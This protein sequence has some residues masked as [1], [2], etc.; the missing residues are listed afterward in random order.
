MTPSLSCCMHVRLTIF[1]FQARERFQQ[2]FNLIQ[3]LIRV[4]RCIIHLSDEQ[5]M[6]TAVEMQWYAL[7]QSKEARKLA[8]N[9]AYYSKSKVTSHILLFQLL[10][11]PQYIEVIL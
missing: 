7:N 10:D 9:P 11:P 1:F 4:M 5:T 2:S 6:R 8:F 3:V